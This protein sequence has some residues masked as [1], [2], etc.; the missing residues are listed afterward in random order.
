MKCLITELNDYLQHQ[1]D[2]TGYIIVE[3]MFIISYNYMF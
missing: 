3:L 1:L 2:L